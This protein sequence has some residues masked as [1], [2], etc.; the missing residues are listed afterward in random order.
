ML[1]PVVPQAYNDS[2]CGVQYSNYQQVAFCDVTVPPVWPAMLQVS[3]P[4]SLACCRRSVGPGVG[5]IIFK[6]TYKTVCVCCHCRLFHD[7]GWR[8]DVC[9]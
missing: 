6:Y 4:V 5:G 8:P 2:Q 9:A 1:Y 7:P 3:D